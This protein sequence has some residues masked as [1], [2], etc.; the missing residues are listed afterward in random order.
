MSFV[1]RD[2]HSKVR[3]IWFMSQN[4][5]RLHFGFFYYLSC[6]MSYLWV[7][8]NAKKVNLCF[9]VRLFK[10]TK[11][12]T[13]SAKVFLTFIF[14]MAL[15]FT[16]KKPRRAAGSCKKLADHQVVVGWKFCTL[17]DTNVQHWL[18]QTAETIQQSVSDGWPSESLHQE[19]LC[20]FKCWCGIRRCCE[21]IPAGSFRYHSC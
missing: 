18:E 16:Q 9:Q 1:N 17:F 13:L 6:E 7:P 8:A 2:Y 20:K 4:L 5:P 14:T 19:Y 10:L 15:H 21:R 12:H 3:E 11:D